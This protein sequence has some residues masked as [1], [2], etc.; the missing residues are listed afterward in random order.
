M[1]RQRYAVPNRIQGRKGIYTTLA[2]HEPLSYKNRNLTN[3]SRSASKALHPITR[4]LLGDINTRLL[5][6]IFE[7]VFDILLA[8]FKLL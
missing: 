5:Q 1:K 8:A 6:S 2:E 7:K 4:T 3:I